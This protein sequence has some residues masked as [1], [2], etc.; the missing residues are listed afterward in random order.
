[1]ARQLVNPNIN[2]TEKAG[3]C[4][5]YARRVFG[6]PAVEPSAWDGWTRAKYRHEDR[7]FPAGVA[8]PVWFDWTGDVGAGRQRYGHVA[9][10]T[11]DGKIWSSPLTGTGRSWFTTVDD[12]TRAFGGGMRYVGWSEDISGVRVIEGEDNQ[13]IQNNDSEYERWGKLHRRVRGNWFTREDF[14]DH[15]VGMDERTFV[16]NVINNP[17]ADY[18]E[19]A[20]DIGNVAIQ[21]N[22]W[23]QINTPQAGIT[24]DEIDEVIKQAQ[25]VLEAAKDLKK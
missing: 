8:V 14:N 23:E 13:V 11:A 20:G 17:Q 16:D 24:D 19:Y 10:R 3:W 12:L 2:I 15:I 21:N 22:W 25:E 5:S 9:V 1:M 6:A 4:L 18:R 7:N